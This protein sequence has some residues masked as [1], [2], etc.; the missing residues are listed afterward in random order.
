[1]SSTVYPSMGAAA[2]TVK[3]KIL[4]TA[5]AALAEET[6][7]DVGMGFMWPPQWQDSVSVMGV[8]VSPSDGTIG[9]Q[10]RQ[11]VDIRQDVAITV[12]RVT[13][14]EGEVHDRA[15]EL[16]D[17]IDSAI[18]TDATLGGTVLWCYADEVAS[19]GI[20]DESNAG[21]GRICALSVT[22]VSRVMITRPA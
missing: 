22:F 16:L 2:A 12:Q 6:E 1:M 18:R 8:R 14:D 7:V 20:T 13:D 4:D 10:R 3:R 15:Y 9:M 19:D 5:K 17:K 21:W 11:H